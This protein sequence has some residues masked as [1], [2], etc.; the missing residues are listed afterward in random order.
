MK[1]FLAIV[2]AL[3]L[4]TAC[5]RREE[6]VLTVD[7][8]NISR[9]EA[10]Y[11]MGAI[12][13]T[14]ALSGEQP[15]MADLRSQTLEVIVDARVLRAK[16]VE[17]GCAP[18][19]EE[20]DGFDAASE[21]ERLYYYEV[22]LARANLLETLFSPSGSMAATDA[23]VME[24]WEKHMVNCAYVFISLYDDENFRITGEDYERL[25][26]VAQALRKQAVNGADFTQLVLDNGMDYAM[27]QSPDGM[28]V[29]K[30]IRGLAFSAAADALQ[31]GEISDLVETDEGL[32]II[33]RI[34]DDPMFLASFR[35]EIEQEYIQ[36]TFVELLAAWRGEAD[37]QITQ[38]FERLTIEG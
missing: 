10:L 32:F 23:A 12:A 14:K 25:V 5:G 17:Y 18:T 9:E 11:V 20:L 34:E 2:C 21:W 4:L 35:A 1:R 24:F 26:L 16:A 36:H 8:E 28:P 19:Q 6:T 33:K 7:G 3:I 13:Q 27:S 15:D 37:T 22:S 38:G 31:P 29:M 30:D